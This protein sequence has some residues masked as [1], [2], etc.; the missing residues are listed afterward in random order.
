MRNL[1]SKAM[2]R[3]MGRP[4]KE[5]EWN[6]HLF[7]QQRCEM[8]E[9]HGIPSTST[10]R[11]GPRRLQRRFPLFTTDPLARLVL[12]ATGL[13]VWSGSPTAS[14]GGEP[15]LAPHPPLPLHGVCFRPPLAHGSSSLH[16]AF[17]FRLVARLASLSP[18][19][20]MALVQPPWT[21]RNDGLYGPRLSPPDE[22][23]RSTDGPSS[24]AHR[25]HLVVLR[26]RSRT[27]IRIAR[28]S[29]AVFFRSVS[30][31]GS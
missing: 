18:S 2:V 23:H 14:T 11:S 4:S 21:V 7:L 28:A 24:N 15:T 30:L 5:P 1:A 20:A 26:A 16:H 8:L 27:R 9:V 29:I 19:M 3:R 6:L 31:P 22:T 13:L 17:S 12:L 10:R 25:R